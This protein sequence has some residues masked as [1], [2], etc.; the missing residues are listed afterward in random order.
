MISF[1]LCS[2]TFRVHVAYTLVFISHDMLLSLEVQKRNVLAHQSSRT[3]M[4]TRECTE[5]G[6]DLL[7]GNIF[8]FHFQLHSEFHFSDTVRLSHL[9]PSASDADVDDVG[10]E[11]FKCYIHFLCTFEDV[12]DWVGTK[13]K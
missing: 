1:P 10:V 3:D 12:S 8:F 13:N 6:R 7:T 2:L 9:K 4:N 11:G 5:S